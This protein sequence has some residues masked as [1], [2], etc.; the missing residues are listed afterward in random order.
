M[1]PF[2]RRRSLLLALLLLLLLGAGGAI[3][4]L[5][6]HKP[7]PDPTTSYIVHAPSDR[8]AW[9]TVT[10]PKPPARDPAQYQI[11][12]GDL[13]AARAALQRAIDATPA[14]QSVGFHLTLAEADDIAALQQIYPA[15]RILWRGDNR[16]HCKAPREIVQALLDNPPPS[17]RFIQPEII[18]VLCNATSAG[19]RF[20]GLSTPLQS[21]VPTLD[22][23]GEIVAVLDT[24][25]S[26]GNPDTLHPDLLP[27]LF[28]M[29]TDP[30]V[31]N[32]ATLLPADSA[33]HGTQVAGS[34]ISRGLTYPGTRSG[35]P[36]AHLFFQ[37]LA[38]EWSL[39][40]LNDLA[41]HFKRSVTVG[42]HIISCSWAQ[43]YASGLGSY[44]QIGLDMDQFVWNNP[45]TL[46]CF[47]V[48]NSG[49]DAD[50]DGVIDLNSVYS[51]NAHA[52]NV[53]TIGAQ[54]GYDPT[55]TG[56][57]N[58]YTSGGGPLAQDLLAAPY[59]G[60]DGVAAFSSR[61]PLE[62][63]RIAPMLLAPGTAI[64]STIDDGGEY[65]NIGTSHSTPQVAASAAV[66]R[67]YLREGLPKAQRI[68]APTAALLRA[69]LILCSDSLAPG[70]YGTDTYREIPEESPN[71][72]EGWGALRLGHHLTGDAT[73]G[74]IDRLTLGQ[75]E[76]GKAIACTI[77]G[78]KAGG[79]LTAVLS[80]IDHHGY[81]VNGETKVSPLVNDYDLTI[82]SPTGK[83]YSLGDHLNPI[84]RITLTAPEAGDYTLVVT[85]SILAEGTGNFAAL[86]WRANTEA[87]ATP[88]S[89][90][91]TPAS[92]ET[93]TL[94]VQPPPGARP[95][96][97]FPLLPAPG[98]H[99][100]PKGFHVR[101]T[102]APKLL[103]TVADAGADV[104][105]ERL[106][107]FVLE[108][109]DGRLQQSTDCGAEIELTQDAELRWYTTF[110]GYSLRLR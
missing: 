60:G 73:L 51:L 94:T 38:Q 93:V 14:D 62:D 85:A 108:T 102:G 40:I 75:E 59:T 58:A 83:Q 70:Q 54:E 36:G 84:E 109:A 98:T 96:L 55:Y 49:K 30:S 42:A 90:D 56:K 13:P 32:A 63:G 61:G 37:R 43:T 41:Q 67:Q 57:N 105:A 23:R 44:S 66:L 21:K 18:V 95:Y 31:P 77:P 39:Y 88:L 53:L 68:S 47:A 48:G 101:L 3:Y 15:L 91:T 11:V 65:R 74:F 52:K 4:R 81:A 45:E 24:G 27:G 25:L 33:G 71:N 104:V 72:V 69:G 19:E 64:K 2:T 110:P 87:G 28:G 22:G 6:F 46:L 16:F 97:D 82:I 50:T 80:W 78:V 12:P 29:V 100:Y 76:A 86:A 35:A 34:V 1:K 9:K 107:G 7:A 17:L 99:T 106:C 26:T 10:L 103:T 8:V 92:D 5:S 89:A 79:E 20:L